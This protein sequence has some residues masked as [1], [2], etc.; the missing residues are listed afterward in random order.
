MAAIRATSVP[1]QEV[2]NGRRPRPRRAAEGGPPAGDDGSG[3]APLSPAR[4]RRAQTAW[5]RRLVA[6]HS[7]D[8]RTVTTV[9]GVFRFASPESVALLGWEPSDLIGRR[10]EELVHPDD[11]ASAAAMRRAVLG[12]PSEVVTR[13]WRLQCADGSYRWTET[14]SRAVEIDGEHLVV[15]AVRD[16][17][18]RKRAELELHRQASTDPVTGI[19][20]RFVFMDRLRQALRRLDRNAGLVAVLYL[21]LDRFK[22]INDAVGHLAG[23]AVLL[24]VAERIRSYLR[25]Q[26]TLA[27]LG[28]DEFAVVVED[29][30]DQAEAMALGAR[31]VQS[32]REPYL[33][34][35]EQFLCTV[36]LG[37]SVTSDPHC[38]AEALLQEADLALY[39]AKKRGRDRV[40]LFDE[41]LR[42]RAVGRLG[43]ERMLRRAIA[44]DRLRVQYQPIIDL[45]TG[46]TV[47]AEA[48]VRVWDPSNERLIQAEFFVDV[49]EEAG[50][51][52]PMDDWVQTE[53]IAQA[54][55]WWE[56]LSG[57]GFA[58][59]SVNITT[60]HLADAGFAT[61]LLADLEASG[62]PASSLQ[63]E[64]T[65]RV[66]TEASTS[67]MVAL[68]SLRSAGVKVGLDDFGT[69]CSS[70]SFLRVIPLDFVKVDRAFVRELD[71]SGAGRAIVGSIIELSHALGMEVVAEGV[72]TAEQHDQLRALGCDRAQGYLFAGAGPAEAIEDR[73]LRAAPGAN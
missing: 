30:T 68:R 38:P 7:P 31:M 28:G 59:L 66:L 21:D 62:L 70:L 18:E 71:R 20:N 67:V 26:D 13:A 34:G 50:L 41:E 57:N 24:Q 51:L 8:L 33:I 32:G 12:G 23:D 63:I 54:S 48:L 55:A 69:G 72:E 17:A 35:D 53:A 39:R 6:D 44:G 25:P 42:T 9:G 36:S 22:L 16:I 1:D 2:R 46:R 64:V 52:G 65:E 27:R 58:D 61:S 3:T 10:Q 49:A 5:L 45:R 43:T 29:M 11:V 14:M 56:P 73:V 19:G 4:A 37:I 15:S 47:G 40:E 60:R